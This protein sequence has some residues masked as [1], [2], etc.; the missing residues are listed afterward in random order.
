MVHSPRHR[1]DLLLVVHVEDCESILWCDRQSERF[2]C[3]DDGSFYS[4]LCPSMNIDSYRQS[5][6]RDWASEWFWT[7]TEN[8]VSKHDDEDENEGERERVLGPFYRSRWW[9]RVNRASC[10]W[11]WSHRD[12]SEPWWKRTSSSELEHLRNEL[13]MNR[14]MRTKASS[15]TFIGH[16]DDETRIARAR[17]TEN[18]PTKDMSR[19]NGREMIEI[20]FQISIGVRITMSNVTR[21]TR[22]TEF[23]NQ[24]EEELHSIDAARLHTYELKVQFIISHISFQEKIIGSLSM[25]SIVDMMTNTMPTLRLFLRI[26]IREEQDLHS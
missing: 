10:N 5:L 17:F 15:P 22:M 1:S 26:D 23:L 18:I 24:R 8:E 16:G 11:N 21:I 19:S 13:S 9:I 4:Y 14:E 7:P 20:I 2:V 6:H 3:E 25:L 12:G